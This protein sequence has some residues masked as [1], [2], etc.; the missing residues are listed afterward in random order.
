[1]TSGAEG[2]AVAL[3]EFGILTADTSGTLCD[4]AV[5]AAVDFVWIDAELTGVSPRECYEVARRLGHTGVATM[6]RVPSCDVLC[7]QEY[8]N[9]GVTEIVLPRVQCLDDVQVAWNAINYPPLGERPRQLG[10]ASAFGHG[11]GWD[12]APRLAV[13]LETLEAFDN[14]SAILGSGLLYGAWIG[15]RDLRDDMTRSGKADGFSE[16][17]QEL[18]DDL[19]AVPDLITGKVFMDAASLLE[20]KREHDNYARMA[21]YWE[22]NLVRELTSLGQSVRSAIGGL[23]KPAG[24]AR[25]RASRSA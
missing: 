13:I 24:S 6:V 2:G 3:Q 15:Y 4:V 22:P 1:M 23:Q 17:V 18:E 14:R 5:A 19:L 16:L 25:T 21:L 20:A 7:V 9:A 12:A 8:A 10:R 11:F